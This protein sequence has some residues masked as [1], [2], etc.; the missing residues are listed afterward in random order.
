[1]ILQIAF[2][3]AVVF[4]LA[5]PHVLVATRRIAIILD[6]SMSMGA[7][8]GSG[9]RLEAAKTQAASL[10]DALP[11]GGR[12]HVYLAGATVAGLGEF[13]DSETF[14]SA[15]GS[16]RATDGPADVTAAIARARTDDSNA[17]IYV[18]SDGV[19]RE[20][21]RD[22]AWVSV[23]ES[24][25]NLALTGLEARRADD[26]SVEVLVAARNFGAAAQRTDVV[27][28]HDSSV[29]GRSAFVLPAA[30]ESSLV[31]RLPDLSGV[32]SAELTTVDA[33][34]ADNV[35]FTVV[36]AP[37]RVRTL[38]MGQA[39][40]VEQ[41]LQ[42][43]PGI[44]LVTAEQV[45]GD[46]PE[47][48]DLVVCVN[49][50]EAPAAGHD[51]GLLL[52]RGGDEGLR[53]PAPLV[54]THTTHPVLQDVAAD[55]VIVAVVDRPSRDGDAGVLARANGVPAVM[56]YERKGRR[57]VEF[58]FDSSASGIG[59]DPSF[60]LL[61]AN[62]VEWL[63]RDE[64]RSVLVAGDPLRRRMAERASDPVVVTGPDG[65][66][67]QHRMDGVDVIA[68]ATTSAGVH[69]VRVGTDAVP[70]VVNP[71]TAVESDLSTVSPAI[72]STVPQTVDAARS[73]VGMTAWLLVA[74]L[75]LLALEWRQRA[76]VRGT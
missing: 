26:G 68:T 37:E 22:V 31:L 34:A 43:H 46:E 63:T 50:E 1:L 69:H 35:R 49:C 41:A 39:H 16:L 30:H 6:V 72:T 61:I 67:I 14:E 65:Q 73:P 54:V 53:E 21:S 47:H 57:T 64:W 13:S 10:I 71:A 59:T 15:L 74:A 33:L 24:V 27:I 12:A 28:K 58:R 38:M 23:G 70:I 19:S 51:A 11:P 55:G 25:D 62:A 48:V 36:P 66:V 5:Q 52:L 18:L 2:V 7:R 60:P 8:D 29:V 9:T 4:A 42:A 76:G 40:F 45:S 32:L 75:A 56:A 17:H 44:R 3:A 20:P